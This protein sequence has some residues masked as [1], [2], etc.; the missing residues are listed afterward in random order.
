MSAHHVVIVGGGF[1]GL[2]AARK[3]RGRN[4]RVTLI[5][6][7]NFHLFQPLL[8]Q[9]ATGGLSPA[10]I[11]TPIRAIVEKQKNVSVLLAT[12]TGFDLANQ[13][14]LLKDGELHYDSLIVA[15]GLRH[16]YFGNDAW[17]EHA[18]GLKS[19]EEATEIRRRVLSAFEAA[20]KETDADKIA[21]LLTFVVIGAGPTGVE[22]AGAIGELSQH[23]LKRNFRR[24]DPASARVLLIE[25]GDRVLPPYH[26]DLSAKAERSLEKLGVTVMTNAMASEIDATG[27]TLSLGKSNDKTERIETR[28]VIWAAGV[29]A[30]PLGELLTENT[31]I[32]TDKIGRVLVKP[33]CSVLQHPNVFVVGDLAHL[34]DA[35]GNLLPGMAPV[36]TQQGQYVAKVITHRLA[37]KEPPPPFRYKDRGKMATIGRAAAVAE[38]GNLRFGGFFAWLVWL[39]IHLYFLIDF[40]NRLLV[41]MQWGWNYITRNRTARLI[42]NDDEGT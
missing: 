34:N 29:K 26:A 32:K 23:T 39:F 11:A 35:D 18:P 6:R 37:E 40:Q 27:V 24:I 15:T 42:T 19:I 28:T 31:G 16:H 9:V 17:R 8:Y 10:N 7:R 3:L 13:R 20:E 5:D 12:A 22:L 14:V 2:A 33:D 41:L 36:A 25:G 4:L 21:A 30:S 1:G 38:V